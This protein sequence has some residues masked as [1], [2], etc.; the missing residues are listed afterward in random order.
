MPETFDLEALVCAARTEPAPAWV[1]RMDRRVT[2][3]VSSPP[4]WW[5]W[6]EMRTGVYTIATAVTAIVLLLG[7]VRLAGSTGSDDSNKSSGGSSSV[8]AMPAVKSEGGKSA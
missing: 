7:V 3:R 2:E 4:R 5:H 6:K 1:G 8:A